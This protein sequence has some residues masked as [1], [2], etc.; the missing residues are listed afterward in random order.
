MKKKILAALLT[1]AMLSALP[2]TAFAVTGSA[3]AA[4]GT[5]SGSG[6]SVGTVTVTVSN[7]VIT[8]VTSSKATK[9]SYQTLVKSWLSKVN[10]TAATYDAVDAVTAATSGKYGTGLKNGTLAALRTAPEAG[11]SA[12]SG[13]S[14][15]TSQPTPAPAGSAVPDGTY[16]GEGSSVGTI[17]V[18]VSNGTISSLT[19]SKATKSSYQT[20]VKNWLNKIKGMTASAET[21]DAVTAATSGK[22]GTGLKNGTLA[23]LNSAAS[24]GGGTG[25]TSEEVIPDETSE[26]GQG[27][28]AKKGTRYTGTG[29]IDSEYVTLD[30]YVKK[31]VINGVFI[32]AEEGSWLNLLTGMQSSFLGIAANAA[33]VDAISSS[34]TLGFRD[35]LRNA[36]SAALQQN[37]GSTGGSV[38]GGTSTGAYKADGW[39]KKYSYTTLKNKQYYY[40][41]FGTYYPVT[42]VYDKSMS[43]DKPYAAY[44]QVGNTRYYLDKAEDDG[45]LSTKWEGAK[46]A[47]KKIY[48]SAKADD[49]AK[50]QREEPQLYTLS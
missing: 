42:P 49:D 43:K 29:T 31:G 12:S 26:I 40:L 23:A 15:N 35:T 39:D 13:N 36:V 11:N 3:S 47:S 19:C 5:Y 30:V 17:T 37:G 16:A 8:N 25:G 34:T 1:A 46:S 27:I 18:T 14:G 50:D 7:G 41:Y 32:A 22:Y 48:E 24:S 4:D 2:A 6:S 21:I 45:T 20:L 44:I 10:G 9:S 33:T 38:S 28:G